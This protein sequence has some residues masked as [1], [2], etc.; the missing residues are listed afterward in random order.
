MLIVAICMKRVRVKQWS[1]DMFVRSIDNLCV[2]LDV[3]GL[4]MLCQ[5]CY[6]MKYDEEFTHK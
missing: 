1:G 2:N 6:R 4:F 3:E 5:N